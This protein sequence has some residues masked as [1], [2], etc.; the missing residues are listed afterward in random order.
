MQKTSADCVAWTNVSAAHIVPKRIYKSRPPYFL[1]PRPPP[2][3]RGGATHNITWG[4]KA[5]ADTG[6][7]VAVRNG[8]EE[9]F[10]RD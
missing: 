3:A 5:A 1:L 9:S 6:R 4:K 2:H 8:W 10:Q 7:V